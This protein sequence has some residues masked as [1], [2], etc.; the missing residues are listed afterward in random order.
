ME[1][2]NDFL[3]GWI[4][5]WSLSKTWPEIKFH[6]PLLCADCPHFSGKF[7]PKPGD[8][9]TCISSRGK[10][11]FLYKSGSIG[12]NGDCGTY[13]LLHHTDGFCPG[14]GI[15]DYDGD[16]NY[17]VLSNKS[18]RC[19]FFKE[20]VKA[21]YKWNAKKLKLTKKAVWTPK[22]GDF[23]YVGKN[24]TNH[25]CFHISKNKSE[26]YASLR[27]S[28]SNLHFGGAAYYKEAKINR[29]GFNITRLLT[30]DEKAKL[31][32]AIKEAGYEWN[33]EEKKVDQF[34]PRCGD[35][36]AWTNYAGDEKWLAC[37]KKYNGRGDNAVG[38]YFGLARNGELFINDSFGCQESHI[39]RLMTE[40]ERLQLLAELTKTGRVWNAEKKCV[41]DIKFVPK[42]GEF[43]VAECGALEPYLFI[44]KSTSKGLSDYVWLCG[45]DLNI[46]SASCYHEDFIFRKQTGAEMKELLSYL[47]KAGKTWNPELKRIEDVKWRA[48]KGGRYWH[49]FC[50]AN[51]GDT[52]YKP[53]RS[54]E[55]RDKFD[56]AMYAQ[57]DYHKTKEDCQRFCDAI[58]LTIK[59][60]K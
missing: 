21:G 51:N 28:D 50:D 22:D 49:S 52:E 30:A 13:A 33:A 6:Q 8:V 54:T 16:T 14:S 38:L 55:N 3:E 11:I 1:D 41:E 32:A 57:R 7:N 46:E 26:Y 4:R 17:W 12:L 47:S 58:N 40:S 25:E 48:E 60:F 27:I 36:A 45:G 35:F 29:G 37:V 31:L 20:M 56:D 53:R 18:D 39:L 19:A 43:C 34:T 9:V 23:C 24:E 59:N 44:A 5:G 10:S 15:T 42:D 2:V